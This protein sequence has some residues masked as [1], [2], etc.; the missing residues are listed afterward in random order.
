[1]C[2]ILSDIIASIW[3]GLRLAGLSSNAQQVFNYK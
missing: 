2:M 3:H 1:M